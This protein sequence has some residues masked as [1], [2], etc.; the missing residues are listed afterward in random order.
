[1]ARYVQLTGG[2]SMDPQAECRQVT[3]MLM[4]IDEIVGIDSVG[5]EI[6]VYTSRYLIPQPSTRS[7]K[8]GQ[9]ELLATLRSGTNNLP[10]A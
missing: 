4:A 7:F 1:M 6:L 3:E 8:L 10:K 9:Q 2:S 5:G